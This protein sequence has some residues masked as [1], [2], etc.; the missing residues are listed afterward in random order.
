MAHPSERP[1]RSGGNDQHDRDCAGY[2]IAMNIITSKKL[3]RLG[4]LTMTMSMAAGPTAALAAPVEQEIPATQSIAQG[5]PE[6]QVKD[7]IIDRHGDDGVKGKIKN[8]TDHTVRVSDPYAGTEG[9][10]A[11]LPPGGEV[12]YYSSRTI[13]IR[14]GRDIVLD[15]EGAYFRL[16]RTGSGNRPVDLWMTDPFVGRPDTLFSDDSVRNLRKGWSEDE[17]H[18]EVSD[19]SS[20]EIKRERDG[21]DGGW[22]N[23]ENR[24]WAVFTVTINR[25]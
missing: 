23:S 3:I 21:W 15:G 5:V 25:I 10:Y 2:L 1:E 4:V 11:L 6:G 12:T 14:N 18:H 8:R 9:I 16:S 22:D 7:L 19:R 17:C 13:D 20:V 24:D